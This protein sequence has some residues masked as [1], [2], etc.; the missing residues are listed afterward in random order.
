MIT[1]FTADVITARDRPDGG[2]EVSGGGLARPRASGM[3]LRCSRT[4]ERDH[5]AVRLDLV[6]VRGPGIHQLA[7][8]LEQVSA[9]IRGLDGARDRVRERHL[10]NFAWEVR[11]LRRPVAER[12]PEAM[13]RDS[14][15]DELPHQPTGDVLANCLARVGTWEDIIRPPAR[16][17]VLEHGERG[18]GQRHAMLAAALHARGGDDP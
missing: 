1:A 4:S 6:A 3:L 2:G 14:A 7:A 16:E 8:L 17:H 9:P 10:G 5:L 13:D 18:G 12:R 15:A 11:A